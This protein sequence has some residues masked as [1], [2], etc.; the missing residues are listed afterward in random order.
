MWEKIFEYLYPKKD[1]DLVY[2]RE[3][4]QLI[5]KKKIK[6]KNRCPS[7]KQKT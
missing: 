1:F 3:C 4:L 5:R 7:R 2:N 6:N